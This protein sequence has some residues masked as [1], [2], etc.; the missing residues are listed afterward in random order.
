MKKIK[1]SCESCGANI[2]LAKNDEKTICLFCGTE[3]LLRKYLLP[4]NR[5]M[6]HDEI[7]AQDNFA[8]PPKP[9]VFDPSMGEVVGTKQKIWLTILPPAIFLLTLIP[10]YLLR[11]L[12]VDNVWGALQERLPESLNWILSFYWVITAGW[13]IFTIIKNVMFFINLVTMIEVMRMPHNLVIAKKQSI[14]LTK[15]IKVSYKRMKEKILKKAETEQ[16][17]WLIASDLSEE[18]IWEEDWHGR[19]EIERDNIKA[20]MYLT[21]IGSREK[22]KSR[23]DTKKSIGGAIVIVSKQGEIFV[24]PKIM[25]LQTVH[26]GLNGQ[27]VA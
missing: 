8:E 27:S 4:E 10:L 5:P 2:R 15:S 6:P 12:I 17:S 24:Q 7:A 9:V 18:T 20:I 25:D 11:D 14:V 22:L 19:E 26:N 13:T 3:Y 23:I 1:L 16:I 21:D